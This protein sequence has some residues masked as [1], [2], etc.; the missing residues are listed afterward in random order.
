MKAISLHEPYASFIMLGWKTIETRLHDKFRSLENQK[1][2]IHRTQTFI[3]PH[4]ADYFQ[5]MS[6][7]Q[8]DQFVNYW[9]KETG[10]NVNKLKKLTPKILGTVE[11][12]K[13]D[14]LNESHSKLAMVDCKHTKRFGLFLRRPKE[15]INQIEFKGRQ[16]I[17]YIRFDIMRTLEYKKSRKDL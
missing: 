14:L 17:F 8:Q 16:G 15:F 9:K 1:I 7:E 13:F 3:M 11:V 4:Q 6:K 10:E 12:Y 2:I 5:Y